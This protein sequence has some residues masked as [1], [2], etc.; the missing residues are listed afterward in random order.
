M[1]VG[2]LLLGAILVFTG[3]VQTWLRHSRPDPDAARRGVRSGKAWNKWTAV[4]G[5]IA[6]VLGIVLI[7]L[8]T[9]GR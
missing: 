6:V 8:G 9:L 5:P 7:V 1:T 2:Y 4:Q 3:A